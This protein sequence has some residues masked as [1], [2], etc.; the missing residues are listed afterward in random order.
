LDVTTPEPKPHTRARRYDKDHTSL[1]NAVIDSYLSF[2]VRLEDNPITAS[3]PDPDVRR[4]LNPFLLAEYISDVE[5]A[6]EW[7]AR[8]HE[9]EI[10]AYLRQL[11][12]LGDAGLSAGMINSLV[13]MCGNEFDKRG[14]SPAKYWHKIK[15][16]AIT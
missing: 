1:F 16:R 6:V 4:A 9:H 12:G 15:R 8:F 13:Q 2:K 3:N 10:I 14:L 7:A 11:S 5:A